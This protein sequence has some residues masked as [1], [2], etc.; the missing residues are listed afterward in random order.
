MSVHA[1]GPFEVN[2]TPEDGM[3]DVGLSRMLI[4][5]Q[6][7]GPLEAMSKGTMLAA[8]TSVKGSAGYVALEL[9]TGSLHGH[10]GSFMLQHAG[11]MTRGVPHLSIAV[12]PD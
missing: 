8:G 2:L 12:V 6:F 5:K 11:T 10:H 4:A 9:V 3:T 1:T 7:H